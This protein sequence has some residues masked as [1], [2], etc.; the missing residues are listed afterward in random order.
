[1]RTVVHQAPEMALSQ[2]MRKK[3]LHKIL[4]FAPNSMTRDL[5]HSIELF[6][7]VA[8]THLLDYCDANLFRFAYSE[9]SYLAKLATDVRSLIGDSFPVAEGARAI[10]P[11][12]GHGYTPILQLLF[13]A[14]SLEGRHANLK[15]AALK[16][17]ECSWL[18]G[19]C[20]QLRFAGSTIPLAT[21]PPQHLQASVIKMLGSHRKS[22]QL[23]S[24]VAKK[25]VITLGEELSS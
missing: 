6:T 11:E 25:A 7:I 1:M 15:L 21:Q 2:H 12:A 9:R 10:V 24:L 8:P 5:L 17:Q 20:E 22:L 3:A 4:R 18:L 19:P 23:D 14:L 16:S 13:N